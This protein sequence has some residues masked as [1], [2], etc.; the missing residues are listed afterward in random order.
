MQIDAAKCGVHA[1]GSHALH[2]AARGCLIVVTILRPPVDDAFLLAFIVNAR[3]LFYALA[4]LER[5][6]G[7]GVKTFYLIYGM[8]DEAFSL[9]YTAR[10]PK[11]VSTGWFYFWV[12]LSIGGG[13]ALYMLLVQTVFR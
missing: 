10:V 5:Y 9:N 2:L 8:C 6:R 13:T 12:T 7:H 1:P 4:M 11:G 3:H